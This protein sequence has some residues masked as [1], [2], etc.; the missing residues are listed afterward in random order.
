MGV[1]V[2]VPTANQPHEACARLHDRSGGSRNPPAGREGGERL[3]PRP[4]V[5][6][7]AQHREERSE[8]PHLELSVTPARPSWVPPNMSVEEA[9]AVIETVARTLAPSFTFPP[10]DLDD[11]KQ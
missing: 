11:I 5:R 1:S 9:L 10:H 3:R 7:L 4:R 2:R 8:G 6:V